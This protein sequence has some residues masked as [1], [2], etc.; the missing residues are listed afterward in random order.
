MKS[1]A[2]AVTLLLSSAAIAQ[3]VQ[4]ETAL[5]P[6]T[7]TAMMPHDSVDSVEHTMMPTTAPEAVAQQPM[8]TTHVSSTTARIVQ[9]SNADPETDARGIKVISAEAM[10]PAGWNGQAGI[11]EGGPLLDPVTGEAM[12]PDNY[13]ACSATVTDNCLQSYERGLST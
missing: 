10:V 5:T 11:A 8:M 13:P 2:L 1:A 7:S 4:P 3:T 9:P 6:D 12:A